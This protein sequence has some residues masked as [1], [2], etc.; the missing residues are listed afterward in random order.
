MRVDISR[1]AEHKL[2]GVGTSRAQALAGKNDIA[3]SRTDNL[4]GAVPELRSANGLSGEARH[5]FEHQ[6]SLIGRSKIRSAGHE[7][8]IGR[9]I[10]ELQGGRGERVVI[11][12]D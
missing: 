9:V 7:G 3:V 8:D 6:R 4:D 11:L 10:K 2:G 5:L 12:Q 1:E